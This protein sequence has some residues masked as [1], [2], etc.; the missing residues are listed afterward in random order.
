MTEEQ[1]KEWKINREKKVNAG[2]GGQLK[3]LQT[4]IENYKTTD[5]ELEKRRARLLEF[6]N[7]PNYVARYVNESGTFGTLCREFLN[8]MNQHGKV[9]ILT[10]VDSSCITSASA[11]PEEGAKLNTK[12]LLE[13]FSATNSANYA[14]DIEEQRASTND[15]SI[16]AARG[17]RV[18]L[19]MSV[20]PL[21]NLPKGST[22]I[23]ME[24][25]PVD[26][27]EAKII[28]K[29]SVEPYQFKALSAIQ[30]KLAYDI[31]KKYSKMSYTKENE[32]QL[33][34]EKRK[35][36][37]AIPIISA[38]LKTSAQS[39]N[40]DEENID[41]IE[42]L[43]IGLGQKR[44][45]ETARK[46]FSE[47]AIE[48]L[49]EDGILESITFD[50][51]ALIKNMMDG[52]QDVWEQEVPGVELRM[53]KV[54]FKD[55]ITKKG[56]EWAS[57][58]GSAF[59]AWRDIQQDDKS[60]GEYKTKISL[61]DQE[62]KKSH[63]DKTKTQLLKSRKGYQDLVFKAVNHKK[64][65]IQLI[66][67]YLV[68]R[69]KPGVG[70]SVW[71]DALA[72]LFG[73]RIYYVDV[74]SVFDMWL[75]NS[76]KNADK[77]LNMITNSRKTVFLLDEIDRTLDQGGGDEG[78]VGGQ[79]GG[80]GA[81]AVEKK[82]MAKFLNTFETDINKLIEKDIFVIMTTNNLNSIGKALLSRTKGNV[83]N[84]EASDDPADYLQFLQ[85]FLD[86]ERKYNPNGPWINSV[87][88]TSEEKWDYTFKFINSLDLKQL[89]KILASKKIGYRT[90]SGLIE[91]AA[92]G[93]Q[94]F[95]N[96]EDSIKRGD[97][98]EPFDIP[99]TTNNI[100]NMAELANDTGSNAEYEAGVGPVTSEV[101]K[102]FREKFPDFANMPKETEEVSSGLGIEGIEGLEDVPQTAYKVPDSVMAV[103][104]GKTYQPP[105]DEPPENAEEIGPQVIIDEQGKKKLVYKP[106]GLGVPDNS[107]QEAPVPSA[108]SEGMD[109]DFFETGE[110]EEEEMPVTTQPSGQLSQ[111]KINLEK[112]KSKNKEKDD[113]KSSKKSST[114]DYL[115]N[116][117]IS[118]GIIDN[119]GNVKA[120][121]N[122]VSQ[123]MITVPDKQKDS[124]EPIK[125]NDS[126]SQSEIE[127]GKKV[128]ENGSQQLDPIAE[129]EKKNVYY[130]NDNQCLIFSIDKDIPPLKFI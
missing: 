109:L 61:I 123:P 70:K 99:M 84:V 57:K 83:Y 5:P 19:L 122:P 128:I 114:T 86:T 25:S 100:C 48:K 46:Y 120:Q 71:A 31:D 90:L 42:Q 33:M 49:D 28:V 56:S 107:M 116:V 75:G 6:L 113:S 102:E 126:I 124:K 125:N 95:L 26:E 129:L 39:A 72:S 4:L 85:G 45:I 29:Y 110:P 18:V 63:D 52:I 43:L 2:A 111:E 62:L 79:G 59:N 103:L 16:K 68:L 93:H 106:K 97:N 17:K 81:H 35:E 51:P 40:I 24:T 105:V 121:Q 130:G 23:N 64:G 58:V 30:G 55:Y 108:S 34:T 94:S 118:K 73:F 77:L 67:H 112:G 78:G 9:V 87:G 8:R 92:K 32:Q 69:G 82:I 98:Y 50:Q 80:G 37:R 66:P 44:A 96:W 21:Q 27:P 7:S 38:G 11:K 13:G 104:N 91:R 127:K 22:L 47:S 53:P 76:E 36:L 54:Q 65:V 115:Y 20:Y 12:G 15:G 101:L 3:T 117:L 10:N 74:S 119:K 60:I 89:A 88:E 1:L 41:T 14:K